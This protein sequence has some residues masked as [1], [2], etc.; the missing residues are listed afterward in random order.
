MTNQQI[1]KSIQSD[2]IIKDLY[3]K[4][5]RLHS[6]YTPKFIVV[7][8]EIYVSYSDKFKRL[9]ATIHEAIE[10]RQEQISNY[11]KPIWDKLNK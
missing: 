3:A 1:I 4:L 5:H 9:E 11:Y 6:S 7:D 8:G 2:I 10:H